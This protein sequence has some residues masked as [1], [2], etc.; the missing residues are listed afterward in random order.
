MVA[1]FR[2]SVSKVYGGNKGVEGNPYSSLS[3]FLCQ[4]RKVKN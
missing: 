4:G 1:A 3:H 2:L